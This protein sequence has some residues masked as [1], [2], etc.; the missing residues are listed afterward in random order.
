MANNIIKVKR[1]NIPSAVPNTTD[2]SNTQYIQAGELA[3][4]MIDGVLYTSNGSADGLIA[5]GA[6]QKTFQT[7]TVTVSDT[8]T[9]GDIADQLLKANSTTMLAGN[10][11][12]N[13]TVNTSSVSVQNTSSNITISAQRIFA[14]NTVSNAQFNLIGGSADLTISSFSYNSTTSIASFQ[15]STPHNLVAPTRGV[16]VTLTNMT[17]ASAVFNGRYE[18]HDIT[19]P[20]DFSIAGVT[21]GGVV[22]TSLPVPISRKNGESIL[23]TQ[24]NHNFPNGAQIIVSGVGPDYKDS[25]FTFDGT[26]TVSN[27]TAASKTVRYQQYP[28]I[29]ASPSFMYKLAGDNFVTYITPTAHNLLA[30]YYVSTNAYPSGISTP[31]RAQGFVNAIAFAALLDTKADSHVGAV[32]G[33]TIVNKQLQGGSVYMLI[34]SSDTDYKIFNSQQTVPV[35][36]H[37]DGGAYEDVYTRTIT[38]AFYDPTTLSKTGEIQNIIITVSNSLFAIGGSI[39]LSGFTGNWTFLNDKQLPISQILTATTYGS[40]LSNGSYTSAPAYDITKCFSINVTGI[41]AVGTIPN[42]NLL[43]FYNSS[44]ASFIVRVPVDMGAVTTSTASQMQSSPYVIRVDKT[45]V[46]GDVTDNT[47][48]VSWGVDGIYRNGFKPEKAKALLPWTSTGWTTGGAPTGGPKTVT[49]TLGVDVSSFSVDQYCLLYGNFAG[50]S[51]GTM[52]VGTNVSNGFAPGI[53]FYKI[54]AVDTVGKKITFDWTNGPLVFDRA[55]SSGRIYYLYFTSGI[56]YSNFIIQPFMTTSSKV[57]LTTTMN[58][59]VNSQQKIN[60]VINSTAFTMQL[61][62]L[63]NAATTT[64]GTY[65]NPLPV[66]GGLF[67]RNTDIGVTTQPGGGTNRNKLSGSPGLITYNATGLVGGD[68]HIDYSLYVEVVNSSAAIM[69]TPSTFYN[70]NTTANLFSNSSAMAISSTSDAFNMGTKGFSLIGTNA[71]KYDPTR[72]H[73]IVNTSIFQLGDGTGKGTTIDASGKIKQ[74]GSELDI[75]TEIA[76]VQLNDYSI[77]INADDLQTSINTS[78]AVFSGNMSIAGSLYVNSSYGISGQVLATD[79]NILYWTDSGIDFTVNQDFGADVSVTGTLSPGVVDVVDDIGNEFKIN[80]DKTYYTS[81]TLEQLT[82]SANSFVMSSND[83]YSNVTTITPT[84]INVGNATVNSTVNSTAFTGTANNTLYVGSITAAN[85]VSNAQLSSNLSNYQTT[86]GLSGNVGALAANSATYLGGNTASNLRTYSE[87]KAGEAYSNAISYSGNAALAYSNAIAY[88]GNAALAYSNAVAKIATSTA[89]NAGYLGGYAADQYAFANAVVSVNLDST[90]AWTNVHTFSNT[91]VFTKGI[92]ANGSNGT[93]GQVLTTAGTGG[94]VYWTTVGTGGVGS[95]TSVGSGN[96]LTGGPITTSGTLSVLA[97]TGI[98]ANSTGLFVDPSYLGGS[99]SNNAS[100]VGGN[101]ASDLRTYSET[102]AGNAYSNAI[103]YSGNAAQAY[104]NA[105]SYSGNAALAYSNAIAYSGNAALAYSNATTYSSNADNIS[106]GTLTEPRLP[107]RLNQNLTTTNNVTFANISITGGTISTAPVYGTD[108]VNKTYADAITSGVNYHPAVRLVTNTEL[109]L[110]TYDNGPSSNG[111]GATLT[112]SSSYGALVVDSVSTAYLDRVLVRLQSNNVLN[113]IYVVSNTGSVSYA[114]VLTRSNDYDQVGTGTNEI[115]KGDITYVLEGTNGAGT[116]WVENSDVT[117][118]G[119]DP[120]TFIQFSSKSVYALSSGSGL[121]YSTGGSYDGSAASTLAVNTTYISTLSSNNA[122]Y[123]G[124]IAAASYVQNTDSRTLS[125]NLYFTGANS[126]FNGKVTLNA[127]VVLNAGIDIIDSTGARGTVGQVLTSN[128][129]GNVY[130]ST[131]ST[132]AG[133]LT[134]VASGNGL[135][136][137]PITSTGTLYVLANTGIVSNA[138]GVFVNATYINTI[139]A[140]AATYLNGKTESNL[141]VNNS[142]TSNTANTANYIIANTGVVSNS[143]GVFVDTTTIAT[144]TYVTGLGYLTSIAGSGNVAYDSSRLG[145]TAAAS[146]VQN[147]DSRTLSG[148]LYFTATNNYISSNLSFANAGAIQIGIYGATNVIGSILSNNGIQIGNS[149]ISIVANTSALTINDTNVT[150]GNVTIAVANISIGNS[151]VRSSVNST[152]FSGTANNATNLG[153]VAAV[154]FVQNTDSRTLSGNLYFT[155]ANTYFGGK[156]THAA[157]LI[158]SAGV[159]VIDSTGSQ[160]ASNQVLTSNGTGNVYWSTVTSGGGGSVNV[161]STY[162]WTNVH[163]FSDT[164]ASGNATSGAIK[165]TGGVGIANN[166]YVGGR[167]GYSNSTNIS[168]A[169]TY[170]N[171]AT[172][173]IDTVFGI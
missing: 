16:Y 161:D 33:G 166:L 58:R 30:N 119:T 118:I 150:T 56:T 24:S 142:V 165:V 113:G 114:W 45:A 164:T 145:G 105:I 3:L 51:K 104:S 20:T 156:V 28:I 86:A 38:S 96:G 103:A 79:G 115:A 15:T 32:A 62:S 14:G 47:S 44:G 34:D 163:T 54:T 82:I 80:A 19:S 22:D 81:N 53:G 88:S 39:L 102:K 89:N 122:S 77:T 139:S 9:I 59:T 2:P 128:G 120:I 70:G 169:Y 98:V 84:R 172:D 11:T 170:Y 167:V 123:L 60:S 127:N 75:G 4:N 108:I 78:S 64:Y 93:A 41:T 117:A 141:N 168:V 125:G 31:I 140:N 87:T 99:S 43:S 121:Y 151:T 73:L 133:T 134:S 137:G 97:N 71:G 40:I 109:T 94:N 37:T 110:I 69:I 6:R 8:F 95:V 52:V 74:Y 72:P 135:S 111:V 158:I 65:A 12:V 57:K 35:T 160:G 173:S 25:N 55:Y 153:G 50:F 26:F 116:A 171:A 154:S 10:T 107:Y 66:I 132:T 100:Y 68:C 90:Y 138:T 27:T 152:T 157:N 144:K 146:F 36:L 67:T 83:T 130:W 17:G 63:E 101:T 5:V 29:T 149:S 136:G 85:V 76:N 126:Y 42:K 124:T 162:A 7:T 18:V 1:T 46:S 112:R 148:N 106:S 159:S 91:I 155:A 129:T 21:F 92:T 131:V 23:V 13:T 49:I 143:S 48:D 61:N 147:T